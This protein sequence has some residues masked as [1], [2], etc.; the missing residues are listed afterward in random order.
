MRI[1]SAGVGVRWQWA[2]RLDLRKRGQAQF[3]QFGHSGIAAQLSEKLSLAPFSCG[4]RQ[5]EAELRRSG[6][7]SSTSR[8]R[9]A[10]ICLRADGCMMHWTT[11]LGENDNDEANHTTRVSR[12]RSRCG[13][14]D[15][16]RFQQS[17]G[18][19]IC[20]AA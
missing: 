6:D 3:F 15:D 19:D 17:D 13:H 18:T 2:R 11:V 14:V 4:R 5:A 12:G 9:R 1:A 7:V 20:N 10:R 16:D 8:R